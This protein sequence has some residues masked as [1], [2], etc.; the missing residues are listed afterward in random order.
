ME[1]APPI[2]YRKIASA[3][4]IT[5][6]GLKHIAA[7]AALSREDFLHPGRVLESLLKTS[8]YRTQLIDKLSQIKTRN[9][10]TKQLLK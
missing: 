2:S 9:Q 3:Y 10:I 7:R 4:G 8:T 5:E 1:I 6:T